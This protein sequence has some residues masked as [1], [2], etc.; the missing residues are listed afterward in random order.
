M[1]LTLLWRSDVSTLQKPVACVTSVRMGGKEERRARPRFFLYFRNHH[2]GNDFD[3]HENETACNLFSYERFRT[4]TRFETEAPE[5]SEM[6][7][8]RH[9]SNL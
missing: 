2:Y 6:A 5:N 3:L 9:K 7:Y 1:T 4:Q 8:F